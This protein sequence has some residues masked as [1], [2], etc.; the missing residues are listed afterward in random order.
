[1]KRDPREQKDKSYS[2]SHILSPFPLLSLSLNQLSWLMF[3]HSCPNHWSPGM[4][5][6]CTE[7]ENGGGGVGGLY[8]WVSDLLVYLDR[9]RMKER[10]RWLH[11]TSQLHFHIDVNKRV[12][13]HCGN[14]HPSLGSQVDTTQGLK[15]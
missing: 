9:L 4:T 12:H 3:A 13:R 14:T 5:K 7:E 15:D 10:H 1:M 6:A 2:V 8:I 11:P